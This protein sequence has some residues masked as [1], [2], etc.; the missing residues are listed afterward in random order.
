V[1]DG[2]RAV[3]GVHVASSVTLGNLFRLTASADWADRATAPR[4]SVAL[5]GELSSRTSR[6]RGDGRSRRV[7]R[8]G[9]SRCA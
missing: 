7:L 9:T 2:R 5:A 4:P 3:C 1:L 8:V 6:R